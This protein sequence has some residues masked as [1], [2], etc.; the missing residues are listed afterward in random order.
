M[1]SSGNH[2]S[3]HAVIKERAR[4]K[5]LHFTLYTKPNYTVQWYHQVLCEKLDRLAKGEIKRLI[6]AMPPQ[7]GKSELVSRRFPAF[8]LGQNP[9]IKIAGASYNH[10]FAAKFNRD[11][12]R[13]I[14]DTTYRS[15]FPDTTIS[16]KF[17][18][19]SAKG[20]WVRNTD[21]VEVVNHEGSYMSVGVGGGLTGNQVDVAIIDDP[22]KDHEEAYS[23]VIREKVWNWYTTVL[24]TRLH[25][26]SRI[27]I[28]MTRWHEDDLVGRLLKLI[29][30]GDIKE[31]WETVIFPAIKENDDDTND[32]RKIGEALWEERH[33][34]ESLLTRR[35]KSERHFQSLYQQHPTPPE[36][37]IF[38][39][40]WIN[41]YKV[42]PDKMDQVIQSWD[43]AF[44]G[45]N[46]SDFVAG[47]V[48]ARKGASF[49]VVHRI[50][51]KMDFP[52]TLEAVNS[53]TRRFPKAKTKL[54]EDKAN[55]PAI[56]ASL[57]DKISGL[58]A[59]N[60]GTDSKASR[61]HAVSFLFEAGNVYFPDP[62]TFNW[63]DD[64]IEE[65]VS[66]PNGTHDDQVDA[67]C[68]GL[69]YLE[70]KSV[71]STRAFVKI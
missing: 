33:S 5:L 7:H 23:D 3:K 31:E 9:N 20:N 35:A 71:N 27:L 64:L 68:Q 40:A 1:K 49:Y 58:I 48:L 54:V 18:Q 12:Q 2:P 22:F 51:E 32:P 17:Q 70:E 11:T 16:G 62:G 52:T 19:T 55:G 59:V 38:Q 45:N 14:D 37:N 46:E 60:P 15:L 67:L 28:T 57:K 65:L 25:N 29:D 8:L 61:A 53:M 34:L 24:E 56:I 6:V 66:F 47:F 13:I 50:K 10:T 42:L 41:Y 39:R 21:M 4:R 26:N 63:V 36:G 69:R 44:K 30:A 43:M